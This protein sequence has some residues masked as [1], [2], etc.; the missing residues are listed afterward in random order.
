MIHSQFYS[1]TYFYP[2][3]INFSADLFDLTSTITPSG[4]GSNVN[5]EVLILRRTPELKPHHQN[6]FYV[7]LR[8]PF[9]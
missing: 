7:L 6:Q 5:E 2:V 8:A 4:T 9:V 3:L 1:F